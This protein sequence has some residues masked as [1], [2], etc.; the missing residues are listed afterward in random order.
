MPS[1]GRPGRK[2]GRSRRRRRTLI[3]CWAMRSRAGRRSRNVRGC[4]NKEQSD[5]DSSGHVGPKPGLGRL[6]NKQIF[7]FWPEGRN[8][9]I[10]T[11]WPQLPCLPF[12]GTCD[13][14]RKNGG[15]YSETSVSLAF[16]KPSAVAFITTSSFSF[17]EFSITSIDF[18]QLPSP[19]CPSV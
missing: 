4:E 5:A 7:A 12:S 10:A 15:P 9:K 11:V 13:K 17:M 3:I 14:R 6:P 16:F 2:C 8:V 1:T 19:L 18:R